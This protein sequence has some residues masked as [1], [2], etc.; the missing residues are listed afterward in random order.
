MFFYDSNTLKVGNYLRIL[1][2][3]EDEIILLMK[4][5]EKLEIKG[6]SLVISFYDKDEV[7]IEGRINS[8]RIIYENN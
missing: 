2:L 8:I 5:N 1:S 7:I 3:K 6:L 4:S